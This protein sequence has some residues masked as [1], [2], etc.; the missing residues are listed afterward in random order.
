MKA[1]PF[2]LT[3]IV[4][5]IALTTGLLAGCGGGGGG[6]SGASFPIAVPTA[7]GTTTQDTT[8]T[9][10]TQTEA[11]PYLSY[12]ETMPV[13]ALPGTNALLKS[14]NGALSISDAA[15]GT[16]DLVPDGQGGYKSSPPFTEVHVSGPVDQPVIS[17]CQ[18]SAT[19]GSVDTKFLLLP[20]GAV[21]VTNAADLAGVTFLAAAGAI[22]GCTP[23]ETAF[24]LKFNADG[25]M[26]NEGVDDNGDPEIKTL[27]PALTAQSLNTTAMDGDDTTALRVY[28]F[29]DGRFLL[30]GELREPDRLTDYD[31]I[32]SR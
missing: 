28:K 31:T 17:L 3:R 20:Q 14:V 26:V 27:S 32:W 24:S 19:T 21:R 10:S 16:V 8:T 13:G 6:S 18:K 5:V 22:V 4:V 29:A 11:T 23:T 25:S 7:A 12:A 30:V 2:A 9:T 1:A 15:F